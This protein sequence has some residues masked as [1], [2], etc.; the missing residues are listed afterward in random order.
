MDA[1]AGR[2]KKQLPKAA[3]DAA[4]DINADLE[5]D[6]KRSRHAV[7]CNAIAQEISEAQG[8]MA[9]LFDG[10]LGAEDFEAFM[11]ADLE[12]QDREEE[13]AIQSEDAQAMDGFVDAPADDLGGNPV[14]THRSST[15]NDFL[16]ALTIELMPNN[17][18]M[19]K[20]TRA[21]IGLCIL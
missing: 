11:A 7:P 5:R 16:H 17:I 19:C 15:V 20:V 4:F 18:V 12:E 10:A 14:E 2:S 9:A 8:A 13:D 3:P 1:D 6:F 21:V